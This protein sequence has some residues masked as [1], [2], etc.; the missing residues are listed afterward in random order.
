ML[1]R[2]QERLLEQHTTIGMM[3]DVCLDAHDVFTA[4][5]IFL[6]RDFKLPR[7]GLWSIFS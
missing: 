4:R 6:M 5:E 7:E 2:Q 3:P 1:L